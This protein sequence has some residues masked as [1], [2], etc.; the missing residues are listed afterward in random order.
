MLELGGGKV[1][2]KEYQLDPIDHHLLHADFYAVAMDKAITVTVPIVLKGE[3]KGVKQQGGIVDFVNREIEVET[4][5][6]DIPE[7]IDIDVSELMLHQGIRVR[8]LPQDGK[9]KPIS[10][11]DMMIV[12]VVTVKA[13][14]P[15][16]EAAAVAARRRRRRP[17]PKSSRRA[18]RRRKTNSR[19]VPMK[20]DDWTRMKLIVGLGNPGRKYEG[21]R[22]NVGFAAV[23][24]LA[25]RHGVQLGVGA[26]RGAGRANGGRRTR[27][28]PSR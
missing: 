20:I 24:L 17:S 1:L 6:A 11:P 15:A 26:G 19:R 16:P 10:E 7:H 2:V 25:R 22:H 3:P 8:D 13:E 14:E 12:H 4:L 21:T 5:P 28:S 9:W 18:R 27:C 23:D